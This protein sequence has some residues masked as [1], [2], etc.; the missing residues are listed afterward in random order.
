MITLLQEPEIRLSTDSANSRETYRIDGHNV[1]FLYH[2]SGWR[3]REFT[4][5][6]ERSLE[7]ELR[8]I[9][10]F[11]PAV[12]VEQAKEIL[13]G[14]Q[15]PIQADA[16]SGSEAAD[17]V[18]ALRPEA[19]QMALAPQSDKLKTLADLLGFQDYMGRYMLLDLNSYVVDSVE[20]YTLAPQ[21]WLKGA[22]KS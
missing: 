4:L 10:L 8:A 6:V 15:S 7:G 18:L 21:V 14:L 2:M 11:L 19:V 9:R 1:P 16:L 13:Q 12:P 3:F 5:E 20:A 22:L 17:L